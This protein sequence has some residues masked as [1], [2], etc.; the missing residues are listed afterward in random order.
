MT[1]NLLLASA[2]GAGSRSVAID[3][4][5]ILAAAAGMVMLLRPLRVAAIP[6]YLLT[7]VLIGPYTT[8]LVGSEGSTE[9]I[10][11]LATILL[12][13]IIGLHLDASGVSGGGK[14]G[15]MVRV[16][17]LAVIS[18]F[19]SVL[20]MWPL[21]G[22]G[23]MGWPA[24]LAVSIAMVMTSTAVMLKI[25]QERRELHRVHGRLIF[26]AL[27][28]QDLIALGGLAV[29]PL[30]ATWAG[31]SARGG[32]G[33]PL[34]PADWPGWAKF[35]LAVGGI[36]ALIGVC[37][38]VLPRLLHEAARHT[39]QEV[40]LV[41]SAAVALGSAILAAG[42]GL[43]P[44]LGAFLAGFVL[45]STPF[46]HQLSGQ[47]IPLR[48]LFM[49]IFFTA[50]GLKLNPFVVQDGWVLIVMA[51]IAISL[52][53]VTV[54][55]LTGWLL[56]ATAPVALLFGVS[57]FSAGEFAIVIL[58]ATERAGLIDGATLSRLIVACVLSL[59]LT[60]TLFSLAH[61]LGPRLARL[62][63]A[64]WSK[65]GPLR[66]DVAPARAPE[67]AREAGETAEPATPSEPAPS[68][69][70]VRARHVV[71]AGYGIVGRAVADRLEMQR[72]P[73]VIVDLN[74]QTITTQRKLGR[75]AVYG[76][77][78]NPQVLESVGIEHAE[79]VVLTIP[80]DEATLRACQTI[81]T[82]S[83]H[84]FIAARTSFLSKA[85]TAHQ[86]GA[87]H[88]TVEEVATAETMARQVVDQLAR[89]GKSPAA[90]AGARG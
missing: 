12:M 33:A 23:P 50:V 86:L 83:P 75:R 71:I 25:L 66:D 3:L 79:A 77:I 16:A 24:G 68:L 58:S 47:L 22:L 7:G 62:P 29:L 73:V 4:L 9:A 31:V 51:F 15:G 48:D 69:E 42:L 70:P 6:A 18:T 1:M 59:V 26:G 78:A 57:M 13:F 40:P 60:P 5:V 27:I 17:L 45:A 82:L 21:F 81:R 55:S 65:A 89:R 38:L 35:A 30:L 20:A 87:D 37:R 88:V 72:V 19:A 2:E 43:S 41:L 34:L 10:G 61:R 44:E 52:V 39:S 53:K 67:P 80:D 46:R 76:D 8:G 84:V 54:M 74:Q 63:V 85:M 14:S 56:G 36:G 64:G 11:G 90:G 49:A 28:V 32:E